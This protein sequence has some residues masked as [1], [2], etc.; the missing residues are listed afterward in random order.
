MGPNQADRCDLPI[1]EGRSRFGL[2]RQPPRIRQTGI[3]TFRRTDACRR[4]QRATSS[5]WWLRPR[6]AG[7]RRAVRRGVALCRF[8]R[9]PAHVGRCA[10]AGFALKTVC[11]RSGRGTSGR[12]TR[13]MPLGPCALL[14]DSQ[15][16][17]TV[18]ADWC[19]AAQSSREQREGRKGRDSGRNAA[20][21][22]TPCLQGG[23]GITVPRAMSSC[24]RCRKSQDPLRRRGGG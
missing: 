9:W 2:L 10:R 20:W 11:C 1:E 23:G 6:R 5:T 3:I 7:W 22:P 16:G 24:R 13:P 21:P 15:R 4:P 12:D 19:P 8:L 18:E 17:G 14:V